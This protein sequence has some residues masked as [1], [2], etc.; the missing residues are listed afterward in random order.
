MNKKHAFFLNKIRI[1]TNLKLL[2][3]KEQIQIKYGYVLYLLL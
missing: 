2:L 1:I 3:N